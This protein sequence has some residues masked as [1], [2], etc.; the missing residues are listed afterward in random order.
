MTKNS[1]LLFSKMKKILSVLIYLLPIVSFAQSGKLFTVGR[2]LSN[3]SINVI[4]Q[5]KSGFIWIGTD[6]GLNCYDGAKFTKFKHVS[7]LSNSLVDNNV[8]SIN[9]EPSGHILIG[10]ARGLQIY[11][12]ATEV[13]KNVNFGY[14][15]EK[16]MGAYVT[17][18][19][20]KKNGEILIGTSGHGLY[21]LIINESN[22]IMSKSKY[23]I[24]AHYINGLFEDHDNNLWIATD[25]NGLLSINRNNRIYKYHVVGYDGLTP[26]GSFFQDSY[27][28]LYVTSTEFGFAKLNKKTKRFIVPKL[29]KANISVI[30]MCQIDKNTLYL[31]T[32]GHG[33]KTYDIPSGVITDS[34]IKLD[35]FDF[36]K[37]EVHSILKDVFGNLWV[38]VNG[39]GV[40]LLPNESGQFKYIGPKSMNSDIIGSN[41]VISIFKDKASVLWLGTANDGLYRITRNGLTVHYTPSSTHGT[42][43]L[44]VSG[45]FQDSNNSYWLISLIDGL[46]HFNPSNGICT[47]VPLFYRQKEVKGVSSITEDKNKNIWVGVMGGGLFRFDMRTRKVYSLKSF[48]GEKDYREYGNAL[49]NR[50]I[51]TLFCSRSNKLYIGS[52]DGLGC[53]D[54]KTMNFVSTY[55]TNRIFAGMIISVIH[56]D[57]LGNIW[58]GTPNGLIRLNEKTRKYKVYTMHYGLPSDAI[59]AIQDDNKNGLWISTDYGLSHYNAKTNKFI[60]F[61]SDDGLQSNEFSKCSSFADK[62]GN[63][64]FGGTDGVTYFNS[65]NLKYS[66]RKPDIKLVGLYINNKS[67]KEGM[68]SGIFTIT[69]NAVYES[70]NFN[71]DNNDNNITLEFSAMDFYNAERITYAYSINNGPW[72]IQRVGINRVTFNNMRSGK[73]TIRIK[74]IDG[75]ASSDIKTIT[76]VIHPAWYASVWAVIIYLILFFI[77]VYAGIVY[78]KNKYKRQKELI[79]RKHSDEINEAKLQFF[80]NI[81]HEIRTPM[82]L[83]ISPLQQLMSSD[84]DTARQK[85]YNIISRNAQRILRLINQLMDVRKIDKGQMSLKFSENDIIKLINNIC[86]D[87]EQQI[88]IK[89]ISFEFHHDLESLN[90]WVDPSNFD[91]II[92]NI[93][94]NAFKFTPNNGN[95]TVNVKKTDMAEIIISN[96]GS[97]I[98]ENEIEKIFERFYQIRNSS[99]NSNV[100]TGIGLHLTRSLVELH[101]GNIHAENNKDGSGCKFIIRLPL[102]NKHLRKDEMEELVVKQITVTEEKKPLVFIDKCKNRRTTKHYILV[103]ED[104]EEIRKYVCSELR[105]E[106]NSKECKNGKEAYEMILSKKPDLVISDVMMPEMDGFSLCK[107]I[108]QNTNINSIPI[109]LL[110]AKTTIEDNIEGLER[111]ADAYITKPFN[112]SLLRKTVENLINSREQL[113]NAYTGKQEQKDKITKLEA[114]SPD[115]KLMERIMKVINSNISNPDLNVEMITKEV[116]I[117]RVHLYRKMKELTNQSMRDFIRNIRLKQ[118]AEL[119]SEKRY[120]VSEVVEMTGFIRVSNFSTLFKNMYGMSPLAYRDLKNKDNKLPE[121]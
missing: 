109:I 2:E 58:V 103:V 80:I 25:D 118:A 45:I 85:T 15:N 60:N 112:I 17:S 33:I 81:S 102:G 94:S 48:N 28:N 20:V 53:L 91:K 61:Y 93:L 62:T 106:F 46:F 84:M 65:N 67:V 71:F 121:E 83:I 104:D 96:S 8:L 75:D 42:I 41:R 86:G 21:N 116:G 77:A 49:H 110:T 5:D 32:I 44:F 27:K 14:K 79:E 38:G 117:S 100:G 82:T 63:L 54:L 22:Y 43:P 18:L 59:S 6:D 105:P 56:E 88:K 90:V 29:W 1:N 13:F 57:K 76:I 92:V 12:K 23:K 51:S 119:L 3:S 36:G 40:I 37:S 120:S 35:T 7:G 50:W 16:K 74:S 113:R 114:K 9:E 99:N 72:N 111:G 55:R 89:N 101:H 70:N 47:K 11:D 69:N 10:T 30:S 26:L 19:L 64:Y 52:C 24:K 34:K 66:T 39:A 73:Y 31:G 87:F 115:D 108:R 78:F 68:K 95:I 107:K 4:F 97:S 98:D